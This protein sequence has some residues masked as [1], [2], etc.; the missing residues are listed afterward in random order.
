MAVR[1]KTILPLRQCNADVYVELSGALVSR[2]RESKVRSPAV[3]L[4][5][6]M[7]T[8]LLRHRNRYSALC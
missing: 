8:W 7:I 4:G 1:R 6:A 2:D 5:M 3:S